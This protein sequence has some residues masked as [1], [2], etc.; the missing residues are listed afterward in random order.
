MDGGLAPVARYCLRCDSCGS[1]QAESASAR[2]DLCG[3][4]WS[5]R[6]R[7]AGGPGRNDPIGDMWDFAAWLPLRDERHRV[8]LGEGAT[9]L[10]AAS[11]SMGCRLSY[12]L[13]C[14]NPTGSQKD[15]GVSV[16]ISKARE[17]GMERVF[18]ASTGSSGLA[19]AAYAARAGI[20]CA[21]L[22]PEGTPA[23]RVTAM[24][25]LGARVI[26]VQG[27]F[28]ETYRM[29]DRL[30]ST[31]GWYLVATNR[32]SN[33]YQAEGSKTLGYEIGLAPGGV[34]EWVVVPVGGGGTLS[35]I[36]RGLRDLRAR[37]L[38]DRLPRLAAAY[39]TRVDR[40]ARAYLADAATDDALRAVP[41]GAGQDTSMFNLKAGER[42]DIADAVAA[43]RESGGAIV[44]IEEEEALSERASLARQEGLVVEPSAAAAA[45]GARKLVQAG[46]F[47]D[48]DRVTAV[49]TGSG[50]RDP[51]PAA[52]AA[53]LRTAPDG[54]LAAIEAFVRPAATNL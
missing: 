22:V 12:K 50:F 49:L 42:S 35:G 31:P 8:S 39:A 48:K 43:V 44:P 45:A 53:P 23:S 2:C 40:F 29:V 25:L 11:S 47:G 26:E 3:G 13:E 28:S 24:S 20:D 30:A 33:P 21:V 18:T 16:A 37:G 17:L 19:C 1:E 51:L 34:P 7:P 9:P 46:T 14:L 52:I 27:G 36:W 15:R 32:R 38:V 5:F 41:A 6:Y 54:R 4:L 10:V